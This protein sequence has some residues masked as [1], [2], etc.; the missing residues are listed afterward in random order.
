M[1]NNN[2]TVVGTQNQVAGRDIINEPI[3]GKP[4][5]NNPNMMACPICHDYWISKDAD[6]CP[7][8]DGDVKKIREEKNVQTNFMFFGGLILCAGMGVKLSE[9]IAISKIAGISITGVSFLILLFVIAF[10]QEC[11]N[12]NGK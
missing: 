9:A 10:I 6:R 12:A 7:G 1:N 2:Q 8:C 11:F 3:T 5:P 4:R